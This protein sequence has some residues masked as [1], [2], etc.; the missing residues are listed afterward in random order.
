MDRVNLLSPNMNKTR[1]FS[2]PTKRAVL[3]R[4]SYY[5]RG[6]EVLVDDKEEEVRWSAFDIYPY[7]YRW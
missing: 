3:R 7:R 6:L 4:G 2:M 5:R 1:K